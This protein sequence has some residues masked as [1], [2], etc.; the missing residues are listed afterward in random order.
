MYRVIKIPLGSLSPALSTE[1]ET[2]AKSHRSA[3][4]EV[5]VEEI[6]ESFGAICLKLMHQIL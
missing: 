4:I 3:I 1:L 5:S 6:R 2:K